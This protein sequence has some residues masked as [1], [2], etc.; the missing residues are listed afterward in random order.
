MKLK[1]Y[2]LK[3]RALH[4]KCSYEEEYYSS[5]IRK[6]IVMNTEFASKTLTAIFAVQI[7]LSGCQPEIEPPIP[8]LP[9]DC[10]YNQTQMAIDTVGSPPTNSNISIQPKFYQGYAINDIC[11]NP[12]DP[13]QLAVV[14]Y[15]FSSEGIIQDIPVFGSAIV[16]IDICTGNTETIYTSN[17]EIR[18]MDW[19]NHD[20]IICAI[21]SHPNSVI[22][23]TSTGSSIVEIPYYNPFIKNIVWHP[24]GETFLLYWDG[25]S[26]VT[27]DMQGVIQSEFTNIYAADFVFLPDGNIGFISYQG[28]GIYNPS[29]NSSSIIDPF[30]I[31][32]T[33]YDIAYCAID[34]TLLWSTDTVTATTNIETGIRSNLALRGEVYRWHHEAATAKNGTLAYVT[35]VVSLS[36]SNTSEWYYRSE[37]RFINADGT[38]ERRLVLDFQ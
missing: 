6:T 24:E 11:F 29:S 19:G 36:L 2:V 21:K 31:L 28:I 27:M 17:R 37:L 22:T 14:L 26:G 7:V 38:N 23:M 5:A 18:C 8:H 25:T 10:S 13:N 33:Q 32:S 12:N 34:H 35:D 4:R 16:I 30:N 9:D 20:K 1:N 15:D 3:S